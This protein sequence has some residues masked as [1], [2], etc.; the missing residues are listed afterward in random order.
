[1]K[2]VNIEVIKKH[3]GLELKAYLPTPHDVWTIGY[4]HTK[5]VKPGQ[6]V[7]KEQAEVF[8]REDLVQAEGVV[9]AMVKVEL[10]QNQF[11]ALVSLVFN[12]GAG[13][14]SKSSVLRF[15]NAGRYTDAADSFRLWNKQRQGS[16][17]V[18]LQGLTKRR[19][20]ERE[21]FLK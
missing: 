17:M 14:F 7:T 12:I 20:E 21:L 9:N 19:K 2:T 10:K 6:A 1:M 11:D 18:E 5:G 3:E 13:N 4:G 8:L 15:L 16:K